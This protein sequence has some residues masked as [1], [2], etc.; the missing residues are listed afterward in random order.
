MC[1]TDIPKHGNQKVDE[2]D[3][4]GE[5]VDAHQRDGDPLREARQI[6][7]IHL[8]TQWLGLIAREGTVGKIICGTCGHRTKKSVMF[9][10]RSKDG[11]RPGDVGSESSDVLGTSFRVSC[12]PDSLLSSHWEI[13]TSLRPR[14]KGGGILVSC[15]CQLDTDWSI[16]G[17]PS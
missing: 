7:L 11:G 17:S 4:G 9:L 12:P 2:Q 15:S 13:V 5:H 14:L 8:H 3:V 16:S 10:W 6:V 1:D